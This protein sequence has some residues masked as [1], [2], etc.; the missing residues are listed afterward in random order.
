MIQYSGSNYAPVFIFSDR[1]NIPNEFDNI[2]YDDCELLKFKTDNEGKLSIIELSKSSYIN[3]EYFVWENKI[4][5]SKYK[6]H[7][8]ASGDISYRLYPSG[9]YFELNPMPSGGALFY[10]TTSGVFKLDTFIRN[11]APIYISGWI[12]TNDPTPLS[13][14]PSFE[15]LLEHQYIPINLSIGIDRELSNDT[16]VAKD[17][18]RYKENVIPILNKNELNNINILEFYFDGRNL[19]TN[20]DFSDETIRKNTHVKYNYLPDKLKLVAKL[21]TNTVGKSEYTPIIDQYILKVSTQ[22]IEK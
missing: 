15:Y 14:K 4:Q 13:G 12:I 3:Y 6:W 10:L 9:T 18:T 8:L 1:I 2:Y 5:D 22:K 11:D 21:N 16:V 19:H 20:Y 7:Y 17:I